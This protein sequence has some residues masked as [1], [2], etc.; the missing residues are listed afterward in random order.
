VVLVGRIPDSLFF[1]SSFTAAPVFM[2]WLG[3]RGLILNLSL[4][5]ALFICV[6]I[7]AALFDLLTGLQSFWPDRLG[8]TRRG[9]VSDRSLDRTSRAR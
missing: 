6:L 5:L 1:W 9:R 4:Y 2:A 7:F 3:F 8:C